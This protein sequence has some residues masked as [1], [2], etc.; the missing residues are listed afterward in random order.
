MCAS[1]IAR[2]LALTRTIPAA[3]CDGCSRRHVALYPTELSGRFCI[4]HLG[5]VADTLE[6][7][8]DT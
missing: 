1:S 4:V 8:H 2:L 5:E 6:G 3:G 7:T